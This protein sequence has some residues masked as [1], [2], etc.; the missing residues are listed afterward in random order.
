MSFLLYHKIGRV[1]GRGVFGCL[2]LISGLAATGLAQLSPMPAGKQQ[3]GLPAQLQNV[4]IDQRLNEQVPLDLV[5]RDE[6]GHPVALRQYFDGKPVILTLVYYE[7]PML[8]TQVLNGVESS[9]KLL[10]L[11][12]GKQFN[13]VT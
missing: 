6:A 10:T 11:D 5:F 2:F 4:G 7:C 12:V 1:S 8:C 9:L 3:T 13:V